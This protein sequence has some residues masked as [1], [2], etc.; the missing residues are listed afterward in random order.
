MT[1]D[2]QPND[3]KSTVEKMFDAEEIKPVG[4]K[5]EVWDVSPIPT[6]EDNFYVGCI[7]KDRLREEEI[8]I[9]RFLQ[10]TGIVEE[11]MAYD[12]KKLV[13]K[14]QAGKNLNSF[15][16]ELNA[17]A[18]HRFCTKFLADFIFISSEWNFS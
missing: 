6:E 5:R 8:D 17:E 3:E 9:L 7:V 13:F 1:R 11:L 15:K 12:K 14:R 16:D 18:T 10:K 4:H 2:V